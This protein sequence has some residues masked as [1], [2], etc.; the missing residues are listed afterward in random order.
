MKSIL[1][2]LVSLILLGNCT[3]P[4]MQ[5]NAPSKTGKNSAKVTFIELG[6]VNCIP[7]MKMQIV[8]REIEQE[9]RDQVA[10][11]F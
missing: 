9:Y 5:S 2:L 6:S 11:V 1:I 7:C 4:D 3:K 8:M 10:I